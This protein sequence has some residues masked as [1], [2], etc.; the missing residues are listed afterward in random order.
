MS[1]DSLE[2]LVEVDQLAEKVVWYFI[3]YILWISLAFDEHN[4]HLHLPADLIMNVSLFT[5]DLTPILGLFLLPPILLHL[6]SQPLPEKA[7]LALELLWLIVSMEILIL[8]WRRHLHNLH[9]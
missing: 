6:L 1:E 5:E 8:L 9:H 2:P 7:K 4:Q 3:Y